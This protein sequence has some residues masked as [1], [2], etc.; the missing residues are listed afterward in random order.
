M[1]VVANIYYSFA[2]IAA[3]VSVKLCL[4][5]SLTSEDVDLEEQLAQNNGYN[6]ICYK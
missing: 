6:I 4:H 3:A 1:L 2:G 5:A